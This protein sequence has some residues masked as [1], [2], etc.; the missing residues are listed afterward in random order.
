[1]VR[2]L[3]VSLLLVGCQ[4]LDYVKVRYVEVQGEA[5][6]DAC[7]RLIGT[8][9]GCVKF[10]GDVAEIY[11]PRP[12]DVRDQQAM[13]VI[14]HEFYCHAWLKQSHTDE[15]GVRRDPWRDCMQEGG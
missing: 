11:A 4:P 8:Y 7:P 9:G 3:A 12:A 2:G 10:R 6:R 15:Q 1:M 14:G 5:L 13:I